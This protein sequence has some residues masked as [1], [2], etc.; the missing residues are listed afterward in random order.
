VAW[1]QGDRSAVDRLLPL[2]HDELHRLA[3]RY[4]AG[5]RAGHTLQTSAL[6]NEAYL[7]LIDVNQV[8]RQNRTHFFA[9]AARTMRRVLVDSARARGNQRR[10]GDIVKVSLDKAAIV[11]PSP[12]QNLIAIDDALARFQTVHPRPAEVVELRFF[13]GLTLEETAAALSVS[14]DTVKRDWRF[15]LGHEDSPGASTARS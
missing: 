13:G 5:E 11:A 10:G 7:R 3:H 1:G 2:V 15:P 8:Q 12:R 4:M 6:V 9:M 14:V